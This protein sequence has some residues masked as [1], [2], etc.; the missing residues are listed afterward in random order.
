MPPLAIQDVTSGSEHNALGPSGNMLRPLGI[1]PVLLQ[2][3]WV[4]L[5]LYISTGSSLSVW[6]SSN[7]KINSHSV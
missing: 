5:Y 4:N 3:P 6:V 2:E 1:Y 7:S